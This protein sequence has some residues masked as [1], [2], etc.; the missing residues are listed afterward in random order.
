MLL[1]HARDAQ[2]AVKQLLELPAENV[3]DSLSEQLSTRAVSRCPVCNRAFRGTSYLKQHMKS[4]TGTVDTCEIRTHSRQATNVPVSEVFSFQGVISSDK[5]SLGSTRN[6]ILM[7][8][9]FN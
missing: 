5:I 3:D 6:G 2:T 8:Q 7:S 1:F 4:H 9:S